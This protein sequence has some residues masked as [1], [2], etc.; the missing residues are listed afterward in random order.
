VFSAK[1]AVNAA[2]SNV[3]TNHSRQTKAASKQ[4][5]AEQSIADKN[6][7]ALSVASTAEVK[8]AA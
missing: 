2:L 3:Y 5:T 8:A 1:T 7:R 6:A 4:Q